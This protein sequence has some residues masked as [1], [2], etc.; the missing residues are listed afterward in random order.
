LS[1]SYSHCVMVYPCAQAILIYAPSNSGPRFNLFQNLTKISVLSKNH[2]LGTAART[3]TRDLAIGEGVGATAGAVIGG[4]V[5]AGATAASDTYPLAGQ[6]IPSGIVA[7]GII[8]TVEALP[9]TYAGGLVDAGLT[10][11][12]CH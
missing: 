2:F 8:G 10:Y 6:T 9:L 3:F 7:G 11:F 5:A 4:L 12:T 1:N